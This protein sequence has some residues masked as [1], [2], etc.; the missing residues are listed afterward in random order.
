VGLA[1]AGVIATTILGV[2]GWIMIP[3][4]ATSWT[5]VI[6]F[7]PLLWAFLESVSDEATEAGRGIARV[8]RLMIA[9]LALMAVVDVATALAIHAGILAADAELVQIRFLGLLR[10]ALFALWGNHLPKLISPWPHGREPF[11]WQGVHRFVG[12]VAVAAGL[13]LMLAW[14]TLPIGGAK[15]ATVLIVITA[16]VLALGR[17][18]VS[19]GTHSG[20]ERRSTS[21]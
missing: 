10:G 14:S 9:A 8:H 12:R 5:F 19:V 7:L 2:V 18:W 20:R 13:A 3:E 11:D 4:K 6:L 21:R 16:S 17:K 1:A 15:R